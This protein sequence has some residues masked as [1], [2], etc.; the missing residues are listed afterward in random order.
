MESDFSTLHERVQ[1]LS[2]E[3]ALLKAQ[4]TKGFG[5][6]SPWLPLKD[7][8]YRLNFRSPRG[9]RNRIKSGK[10][11]PDCFRVDPTASGKVPKYLIHVE[12]YINQLR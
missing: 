9:L 11:P 8:A 4:Q 10:F 5:K 6:S 3:I 2:A 7:A 1:Q 12:R